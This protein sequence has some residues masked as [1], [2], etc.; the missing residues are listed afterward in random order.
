MKKNIQI[1][2][3][4]IFLVFGKIMNYVNVNGKL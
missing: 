3:L 2:N 1:N 4:N